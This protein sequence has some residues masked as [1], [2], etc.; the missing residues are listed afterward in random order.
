MNERMNGRVYMSMQVASV[1]PKAQVHFQLVL[2]SLAI[3][4]TNRSANFL[5]SNVSNI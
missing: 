1:P 3:L 2:M 5:R 4:A